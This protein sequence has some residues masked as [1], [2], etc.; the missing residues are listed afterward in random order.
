VPELPDVTVYL[1]ALRPRIVG[2][3]LEGVT[4][5]SPFF[6]RTFEPPVE[7]CLGR[8]VEGVERLGKRIVVALE[9]RAQSDLFLVIHLMIA[10]RLRWKDPGAKPTGKIDLAALSF[11]SGTLIITEASPKKRAS[12]HIVAGRA[13]LDLMNPGG[14]DPLTCTQG[15]FAAALARENRTLKR[16]LASPHLFDGI[17]NA[18]SDEILHAAKLSPFKR[19]ADLSAEEAEVLREATVARLGE[20][21]A[22]YSQTIALP[23]PDKL[24]M[25]LTVHRQNGHPCPR[26]GDRLEAVFYEDYVMCYC[27]KCQ[28]DGRILKDRRL[29]RLLK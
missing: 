1:D 11:D 15:Q 17:G 7:A 6:L 27:P 2:R 13:A 22:H 3:A 19:G 25:P 14:V 28:T 10:G 20:V 18:Y 26:C 29:S 4:I 21:I 24:P 9:P 23:I 8:R 16:A 12:L 5:R